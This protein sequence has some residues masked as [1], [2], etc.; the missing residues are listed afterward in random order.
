MT[1]REIR[2]ACLM[3][4][5][6]LLKQSGSLSSAAAW[7]EVRLQGTQIVCKAAQTEDHGF[8]DTTIRRFNRESSSLDTASSTHDHFE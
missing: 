8:C 5:S 4:C 1:P 6:I 7:V 2:R 3:S